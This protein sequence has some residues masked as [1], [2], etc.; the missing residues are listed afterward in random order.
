MKDSYEKEKCKC[1]H[2]RKSH[3]SIVGLIG[4]GLRTYLGCRFCKCQRFEQEAIM[5]RNKTMEG[6][7]KI[8]DAILDSDFFKNELKE[9]PIEQRRS[10]DIEK[11]GYPDRYTDYHRNIL[12]WFFEQDL[13]DILK[14]EAV[15]LWLSEELRHDLNGLWIDKNAVLKLDTGDYLCGARSIGD[16]LKEL[17]QDVSDLYEERLNGVWKGLTVKQATKLL[18]DTGVYVALLNEKGKVTGEPIPAIMRPSV[19]VTAQIV[20]EHHPFGSS[21]W[22]HIDFNH[23]IDRKSL[24]GETMKIGG[25]AHRVKF[26]EKGFAI[27]TK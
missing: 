22:L 3:R 14:V 20:L 7:E 25:H 2:Q 17:E 15:W 24:S 8:L 13:K 9:N 10:E 6:M 19:K 4:G 1:G 5:M 21:R 27:I 23:S 18:K 26:D 16:I 12:D 11:Q